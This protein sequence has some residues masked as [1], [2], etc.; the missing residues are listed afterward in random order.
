[1][2]AYYIDKYEVTVGQF[3]AFLNAH[4]TTRSPDGIRWIDLEDG[5]L[6][7]PP[8]YQEGGNFEP[9]FPDS[10]E[11][12]V[13]R[14]TWYG[15][16]AYCEWAGL[17]LPTEAQWEKAARGADGR[18]YPWGEGIDFSKASSGPN[19]GKAGP[20]SSDGFWWTAPVGS[21]PDGI[22][23]YGALDMAGNVWEW[24][25]DWWAKDY[26]AVSPYRNPT[27]PESG[28]SRVIKGGSWFNSPGTQLATWRRGP[29]GP[30][31]AA[32]YQGFRCAKDAQNSSA[33]PEGSWGQL[34][35]QVQSPLE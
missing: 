12:P 27:G 16:Q 17:R 10:G 19:T 3:L 35:K 7:I 11:H 14:V 20:D 32:P 1:M 25:A 31:A 24:V 9:T 2:D 34:K 5:A 22:S 8:Y 18:T 15:A 21:F 4:G 30:S 26:F 29:V 23:P 6:G 13:A 33:V 28:T